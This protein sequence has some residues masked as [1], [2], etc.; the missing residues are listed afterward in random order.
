MVIK[1]CI[2]CGRELPLTK[3]KYTS[4]ASS[5]DAHTAKCKDCI[6]GTLKSHE[7][8]EHRKNNNY[9]PGSDFWY[10]NCLK[11]DN[12]KCV[13]CGVE[14]DLIVHHIDGSR[15][16]GIKKMNNNLDNL[17]TLCKPCHARK[18][19][20]TAD[21]EDVIEMREGGMTFQEIGDKLGLSRQ[22]AHQ[23][24]QRHLPIDIY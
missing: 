15:K 24:Y 12:Y 1:V 11:R 23:L 20:Y 22:R 18:H 19:G 8:K 16:L 3:F 2:K 9:Q 7:V 5:P 21:H 17:L 13:D 4:Y 14:I 6:R 10:I